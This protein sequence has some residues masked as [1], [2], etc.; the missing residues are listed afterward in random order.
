LT[1]NSQ[2]LESFQMK[3]LLKFNLQSWYCYFFF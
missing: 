3:T 2:R 1:N